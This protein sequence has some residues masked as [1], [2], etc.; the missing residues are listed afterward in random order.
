MVTDENVPLINL[1]IF[2][3]VG[4]YV[5]FGSTAFKVQKAGCSVP[6]VAR[7][8]LGPEDFECSSTTHNV[9]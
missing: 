9:A 8:L 1:K 2:F 5:A 6:S 3:N 7:A 4:G